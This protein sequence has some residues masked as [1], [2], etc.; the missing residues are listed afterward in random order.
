MSEKST[1]LPIPREIKRLDDDHLQISW[2]DG[3]VCTYPHSLLRR[4]CPCA[5]CN[6]E[7]AKKDDEMTGMLRIVTTAAPAKYIPTN[8]ALVGRY[9]IQIDWN[10]GHN[11][12]I[13]T[14]T[15]LRKL[16]PE[17]LPQGPD[18][19]RHNEFGELQDV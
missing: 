3:L 19:L 15:L 14:Y 10:D 8:I 2:H 16:C 13:Y 5:S 4:E 7:R 17:L 1:S 11:T 18:S 12:G 6:E 9:A